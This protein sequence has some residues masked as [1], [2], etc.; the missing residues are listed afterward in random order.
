MASPAFDALVQR[1]SDMYHR[2]FTQMDPVEVQAIAEAMLR[3]AR[4]PFELVEL[5][6]HLHNYSYNYHRDAI[7]SAAAA[8]FFE[9]R[10][11]ALRNPKMSP[12]STKGRRSR[13]F[14]PPLNVFSEAVRRAYRDE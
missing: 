12:K 13:S 5:E 4:T 11:A 7:V 6:R 3:L 1:L 14:V 10:V 9:S 8:D 2:G